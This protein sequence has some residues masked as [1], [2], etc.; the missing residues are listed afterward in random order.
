[1]PISKNYDLAW[2][3]LLTD[4]TTDTFIPASDFV[5]GAGFQNARSFRSQ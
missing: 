5:P 4:S 3:T 2:T 1:M